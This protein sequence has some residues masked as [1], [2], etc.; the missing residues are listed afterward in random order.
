MADQSHAFER[1]PKRAG[2]IEK[3]RHA[4]VIKPGVFFKFGFVLPS[5]GQDLG[6]LL[7]A[8]GAGMDENI[9]KKAARGERLGDPPRVCATTLSQLARV[10]VAPCSELSLGVTNEK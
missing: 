10:V 2:T 5:S 1:M 9:R 8:G 6:R 4:R 3:R 7:R